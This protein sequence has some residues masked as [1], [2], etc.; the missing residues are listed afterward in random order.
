MRFATKGRK[1][2]P[3]PRIHHST[4]VLSEYRVAAVIGSLRVWDTDWVNLNP[5]MAPI[6]S[7]LGT[8]MG[9]SRVTLLF[10]AISREVTVPSSYSIRK[11]DEAP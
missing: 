7:S 1:S 2:L 4:S 6:N 3:F 8:V 9:V 5:T 11:Y 10:E